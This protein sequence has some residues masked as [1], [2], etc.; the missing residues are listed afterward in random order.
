MYVDKSLKIKKAHPAM[1]TKAKI[2]KAEGKNTEA[3]KTAKEA[4]ELA[5]KAESKGWAS[6]IEGNIKAWEK[7]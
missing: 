1:F 5:N 2:L 4:L 7:M 3:I 6:Y